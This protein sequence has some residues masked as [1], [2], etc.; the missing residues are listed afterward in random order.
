MLASSAGRAMARLFVPNWRPAVAYARHQNRPDAARWQIP[1][2]PQTRTEWFAADITTALHEA[3][4]GNLMIA[5]QLCRALRRDGTLAGLLSARSGGLVGLAKIFRGD[6]ALVDYWE[7]DG[8][9]GGEFD[10]VF[11]AVELAL[12]V[13]DGILLGVG[14][15]ELVED[16]HGCRHFVRL[17]PEHLR[18]RKEEDRWYYQTMAGLSPVN[19]GD[20]RWILHQ[21]GGYLSP[22]QQGL[23]AALGRAWIS[24]DHAISYRDSYN[25]KLANPARAAITPAGATQGE[26]QGWLEDVIAWGVNTVFEMPPGWE[27]KLIE[28]N[29]VGYEVFLQTI[30]AADREFS[31]CLSGQEPTTDGGKAFGNMEVHDRV[32]TDIIKSDGIG[33]SRTITTQ[34]LRPLSIEMFGEC[35]VSVLWDTKKPADLEKL[36]K[37]IEAMGTSIV[38]ANGALAAEGRKIDVLDYV[39]KFGV[40]I[41]KESADPDAPRALPEGVTNRLGGPQGEPKASAG[42]VHRLPSAS[43]PATAETEDA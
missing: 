27:V 3:D 39:K 32:R 4:Q 7:G 42:P 6:A 26:R 10:R 24:K 35:G 21:P 2:G 22:W 30:E 13:G 15:G 28:S 9:D 34:G 16:E 1:L 8:E 17:D 23:F 12:I 14:I 19:P 41:A 25:S 33:L 29:G 43:S 37:S 20:G 38:A 11:S 31:I 18:Y 36:A 40:L 5:G